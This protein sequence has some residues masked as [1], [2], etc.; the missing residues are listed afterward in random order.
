M[1][2]MTWADVGRRFFCVRRRRTMHQA[3]HQ[4]ERYESKKSCFYIIFTLFLHALMAKKHFI[5]V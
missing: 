4:T 1:H 2:R 5:I 3:M